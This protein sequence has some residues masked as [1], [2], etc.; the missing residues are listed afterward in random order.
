MSLRPFIRTEPQF[1]VTVESE[2]GESELMLVDPQGRGR[3]LPQNAIRVLSF[4]YV[5]SERRA[6]TLRLTVDNHDLQNFDDPV[7]KKGNIIRASWGYPGRMSAP[8]E[9]VVT[10]VTGFTEL[11]V[12]AQARS[13]LM[14]RVV[15]NRLFENM[16]RSDVVRQ[17]AQESGFGDV[18]I[19]DTDVVLESVQQARMTD[20]QF[21]RQ[22]A[23]EEGFQ[24]FVD[25][26]GFHFHRRRTD[27]RP[28]RRFRW[29][30]SRDAGEIISINVENDVTARPGRVRT[31]GRNPLEGEDV[32]G[33]SGA[34]GAAAGGDTA[35]APVFEI[36]DPETRT[37]SV[38]PDYDRQPDS[39]EEHVAQDEVRP[40]STHS[41][42]VAARQARA[43]A[44]RHRQMAV[45]LTMECIG[46]PQMYAKT[47]FQLDG[48][49]RRLSIRYYTKE[50]THVVD[51]SGYVMTVKAV[52]DGHGGH[53]VSS[54]AADGLELLDPGPANQGRRNRQEGEESE[55][56]R[57]DGP[58]DA[59]PTA[60]Y[61]TVDPETR[62]TTITYG[63]PSGRAARSR[64]TTTTTP[65]ATSGD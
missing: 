36:I 1:W 35:L 26:D 61:E 4:A 56:E 38:N 42:D 52:S 19:E 30:T 22:L 14:N 17:I 45:K 7:W 11:T 3:P 46:D 58:G 28:V 33:D 60:P 63:Q 9:L 29:Y 32:E 16:R 53:A 31:R 50:V 39:H 40:T 27:E 43:R 24:F 47:V 18:E 21:V 2:A 54:R 15:R 12:E 10:K 59:R 48:A 20:A 62:R 25:W 49:G 34:G 51:G 41:P 37:G 8:R 23:D 65:A 57:R 55:E 64:T 13:I 5:D 44:R 6:D